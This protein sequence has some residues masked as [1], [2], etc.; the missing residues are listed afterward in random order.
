[1]SRFA[2]WTVC[3]AMGVIAC[4]AVAQ[5][6]A[7]PAVEVRRVAAAEADQGVA[8]DGKFFYAISNHEIGKYDKVS[9]RRVG[10]WRGDPAVYIH[11]NSCSVVRSDLVCAMSNFPGVPMGSSVE[12]FSTATL[13][14]LRSHSFGPGR[15]SLTW[16]D[17]HNGHWWA[18]FANYDGKG[19]EPLRDHLSTV[20]V[21]MGPDFREEE[22]WLFPLNT[23]ERFGHFSASGGRWGQGGLLYVTGHNLPEMYVLKLPEAG[24]RLAYVA[25]ITLPTPGQAFD[26]EYGHP[27]LVWSIERKNKEV[28]ESRLPR[29]PDQIGSVRVSVGSH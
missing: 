10:G 20:L 23:L 29:L 11:I 5:G 15:G 14:H 24:P 19:G 27:E 16:I 28:V 1:M 8:T 13:K 12:F 7:F 3:L 17:W 22:A 26:W 6:A 4:G 9:G 2:A 21:R 18:C 25:T